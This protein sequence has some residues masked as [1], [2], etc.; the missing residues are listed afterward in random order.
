MAWMAVGTLGMALIGCAHDKPHEYGRERPPVDEV[1]SRDTGLQS[2]DI[3]A[4]TDKMASSLLAL[5][6]LNASQAQWTIVVDR[7]DDLT[8]DRNFRQNYQIFLDSLRTKLFK[9]GHGRVTL[10]ENK[11]QFNNLRSRE[12][13]LP[14]DDFGQGA[15]GQPPAPGAV[16]PDF[17]LYAKISDMPNRGTNYYQ[18]DFTL[19][20]LHT[21]TLAWTDEYAVRVAR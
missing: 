20:N 10:I 8:S 17:S 21:R 7:M 12:L 16:Q 19:T 15:G 9:Y 14:R 18:I 1:D 3:A 2:Y 5:P 13:D 4:A 11:G 6:A